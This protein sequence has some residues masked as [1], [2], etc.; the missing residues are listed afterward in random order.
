L[1]VPLAYVLSGRD[2]SVCFRPRNGVSIEV[3]ISSKIVRSL[4]FF[5]D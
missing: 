5:S 4:F 2:T 1:M 3:S